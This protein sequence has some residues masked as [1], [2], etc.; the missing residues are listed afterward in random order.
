MPG[1]LLNGTLS[2]ELN[3]AKNVL[4]YGAKGDETTDD[5]PAIQAVLDSLKTTGGTIYFPN[6]VYSVKTAIQFYSNQILLF[7][8]GATIL[9]GKA[10]NNIFRSY[11]EPEWTGYTG[12]H[13]SWIVGATFQGNAA[14][15]LSTTLA[16]IVHCNNVA[17]VGCKFLNPPG[18]WH[19]MEVSASS[20]IK[21][22]GCEFGGHAGQEM[23]Q[24]DED[25]SSGS[26]PWE[27]AAHDGTGCD[28]VLIDG[29][30]FNTSPNS[31]GIG[32]H[33]GRAFD[34]ITITNCTFD[35]IDTC[36][37]FAGGAQNVL[38]AGN[39]I[40][41]CTN[42]ITYASA[43]TFASGNQFDGITTVMGGSGAAHNNMVNGAYVA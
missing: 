32:T 31:Y 34:K 7:E 14:F 12:T 41:N 39:T 4:T 11:C 37:R 6:R 9:Q 35:G 38:F 10:I 24:I 8:P 13:D 15:S 16:G 2:A 29:C 21:V 1:Y 27:G 30:L 5:A 19:C 3:N 33:H 17:F 43:K 23:L 22:L 25:I 36:V 42:G 20:N 28:N 40:K 18:S 26:W